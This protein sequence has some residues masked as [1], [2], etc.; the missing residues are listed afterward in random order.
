MKIKNATIE[1]LLEDIGNEKSIKKYF[2]LVYT[3]SSDEHQT[4]ILGSRT[5]ERVSFKSLKNCV[6]NKN[7]CLIKIEESE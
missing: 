5:V 2:V 4:P 6:K 1:E 7:S 3:E